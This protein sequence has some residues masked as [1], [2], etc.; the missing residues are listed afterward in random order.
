MV[1]SMSQRGM[2]R[3]VAMMLAGLLALY[4][5]PMA[6]T[7][8]VAA[9]VGGFE[10]EGDL[11][12]SPAGGAIDWF[13]LG[14]GSPGFSTG[15]D[16]VDDTGQDT[17]TFK[18]A[19][20]EFNLQAE[21]GGWPNWQFGSGNA[22][23]KSDFG[24]WATYDFVDDNDHVWFFFGFDRGFGT[25][26]AK[27]AFELNQLTQDPTTDP[28]PDR[29]QGDIRLVIYDQGNGV[30]TLTEDA[31]NPDVGLY[32]WDDPDFAGLGAAGPDADEDGV[33]VKSADQTGVFSGASNIG[34]TSV[35]VPTWWTGGNVVNGTLTKDT[36]L[37]FGMDLT[38]FGA[39]LGCPSAGFSAVNARSITGTG[40]PGTL[41]DYLAA[42]PV[43]IPSTCAN[44]VINKEDQNGDPL[45]GATFRIEPNPLPVGTPNRPSDDFL[46][47]F[48]DSD[49]NT[50][51]EG[52]TNY[53]DP[54]ATAGRITLA[55]VVPGVEY[56][57]TEVAAP[58]G[59]IGDPDD[60]TI[61]P[62]PFSEGNEVTFVNTLPPPGQ[63]TI[64]K[65]LTGPIAGASTDFTVR[66]NCSVDS[67]DQNIVLSAPNWSRTLAI[68][69]GT[70]CSV[71]ETGVPAGWSLTS[72][73]PTGDFTV[74]SNTTVTVTVTNA[75]T[76]GVITVNKNLVGAS[77]GTSV[78]FTFDVDC[79]GTEF[80][81][82][83]TI[84]L[85]GATSGS[86]TTG[87]IPTGLSCTVTERS[88]P[89]WTLTSVVPAGGVVSVP[90]T[91]T[92]TNTAETEVLPVKEGNPPAVLPRT[93]ALV[94][95]LA[96]AAVGMIGL[97]LLLM[98]A[99][100]RREIDS[101]LQ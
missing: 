38:S 55:A 36:F 84:A 48:D 62:E 79:P 81:Q 97:G 9:E 46:T 68:P 11:I 71:T 51:L 19:S 64:R 44:L 31:Q 70:V 28:N 89:N 58:A 91:V 88:T 59:Y 32:V 82:S 21:A 100:R 47:I 23:G 65:V 73:S 78:S 15:V 75:R 92:F 76:F 22:T 5:V 30:V 60:Q 25:G 96:A 90:G 93:G 43:T 86:K 16:N 83:L 45:G 26:T 7:P 29:S 39:V 50:S 14:P 24:R 52:T 85:S 3:T 80:D 49:G 13:N 67:L 72:I 34:D 17:T 66:L 35:A 63:L 69:A 98:A 33:W 77:S 8:A 41:V 2:P 74:G 54:D 57:I 6:A 94:G 87:Q 18:G 56:T 53:D 4:F 20:K 99:G 101:R 61:T 12:D 95:Q 42:I 40:G 27:Y 37:E 1:R 10:I